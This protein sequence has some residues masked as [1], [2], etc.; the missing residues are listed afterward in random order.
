MELGAYVAPLNREPFEDV[1]TFVAE[2]GLTS[3]E[4]GAGGFDRNTLLPVTELLSHA[5]QRA[6]WVARVRSHGLTVSALN[7]NGN[8][9]HPD[10]RIGA[11]HG[12][13]VR[14]AIELA[15][16]LGVRNV[17][18]MS[19]LPGT[20]SGG[21]TPNWAIALWQSEF[22]D[23]LDWQWSNVALPY[24]R[25][26]AALAEAR[27]VRV[28]IEPHPHTL[29]FNP[30]TLERLLDGVGSSAL[31]VN[32]DPSHFFWQGIDALEAVRRLGSRVY[33]AAAKDT[34]IDESAVRSHG[35]L[36]ERRY[37]LEPNAGGKIMATRADGTEIVPVKAP[38]GAAWRFVAVGRS[39]S[40][41]F[42]RQFR[43]A[44]TDVG[45]DAM[46]IE[47]EDADLPAHEGFRRAAAILTT[48][49]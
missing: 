39:H 29:T 13:D 31:G 34:L 47:H 14:A 30:S 10:A 37:R 27:G 4:V 36:D 25:D 42:W 38:D 24:W 8:P 17:I 40:P 28:C 20:P 19:G 43:D 16:L 49:Q 21:V 7:C 32:L 1:L 48:D 15:S 18:S 33:H 44:C 6:D 3:I 12:G 11:E 46:S 41:E 2:L 35:W 45:C 5:N 23:M 26:I 9:L 22:V